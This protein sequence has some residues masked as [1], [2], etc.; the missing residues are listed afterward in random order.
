ME[1]EEPYVLFQESPHHSYKTT[2]RKYLK[3]WILQ[4]LSIFN[5][6]MTLS[7]KT[8]IS[9]KLIHVFQLLHLFYTS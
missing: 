3:N 7:E 8:T 5:L 1:P 6:F 4:V 2:Q 9:L